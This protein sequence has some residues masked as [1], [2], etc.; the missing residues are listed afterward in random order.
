M[1]TGQ[2]NACEDMLS[3]GLGSGTNIAKI[4]LESWWAGYFWASS[5]ATNLD[6]G[7]G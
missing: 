2:G 6:V 5:G 3:K 1:Y 7:L 4:V